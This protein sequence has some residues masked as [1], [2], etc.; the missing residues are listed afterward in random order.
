MGGRIAVLLMM[1]RLFAIGS[2]V[3]ASIRRGLN[4]SAP[5]RED[6]MGGSPEVKR[7]CAR[8]SELGEQP[9]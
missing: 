8:L 1:K 4:A 9:G 6:M 2:A 7:L 3:R 5:T